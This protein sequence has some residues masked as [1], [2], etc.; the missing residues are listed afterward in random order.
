M[1]HGFDS[2]GHCSAWQG[3]EPSWVVRKLKE[4]KGRP[5]PATPTLTAQSRVV[6]G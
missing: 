6:Q 1:L 5:E 3:D 2:A 4:E